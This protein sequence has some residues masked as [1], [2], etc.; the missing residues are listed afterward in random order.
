[1]VCNEKRLPNHLP[2]QIGSLRG[3]ISH[4]ALGKRLRIIVERRRAC[5]FAG[6]GSLLEADFR[7]F[8]Q[9]LKIDPELFARQ[10]SETLGGGTESLA[11]Y[12]Q[13]SVP[14]VE[15]RKPRWIPIK[16]LS[17]GCRRPAGLGGRPSQYQGPDQIRQ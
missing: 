15:A 16:W 1:V 6:T 14:V 17:A 13:S 8:A 3:D 11:R 7:K 5:Y 9:A 2:I 10:N 4:E 12:A